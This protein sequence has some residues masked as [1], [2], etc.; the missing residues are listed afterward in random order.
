MGM[1]LRSMTLK[2][3]MAAQAFDSSIWEHSWVWGQPGLHREL[4]GCRVRPCLKTK[5]WS[6]NEN[7]HRV[8]SMKLNERV[9]LQKTLQ[10]IKPS[11]GAGDIGIPG[12]F[13]HAINLH[14]ERRGRGLG[15]HSRIVTA[16]CWQSCEVSRRAKWRQLT[17]KLR[18]GCVCSRF[19]SYFSVAA[20]V[21]VHT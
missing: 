21:L 1:T 2:S 10:N 11:Y 3:G 12:I 8:R 6:K 14:L 18:C 20:H 13:M 5:R 7:K 15:T 4:Q 16:S 19:P 17:N 9:Q